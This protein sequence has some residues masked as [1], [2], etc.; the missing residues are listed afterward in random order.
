M[1]SSQCNLQLDYIFINEFKKWVELKH[2]FSKLT[3]FCIVTIYLK[4][5]HIQ[6]NKKISYY[7]SFILALSLT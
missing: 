3:S 6:I 5:I 1:L 2:N 4:N 7:E